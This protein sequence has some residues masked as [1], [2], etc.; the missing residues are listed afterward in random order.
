MLRAKQV[1][2]RE[3]SD[4]RNTSLKSHTTAMESGP[5]FCWHTCFPKIKFLHV[6]GHVLLYLEKTQ[7]Q[8]AISPNETTHSLDKN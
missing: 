6:V 7:E 2:T 8:T 3:E 1:S 5:Q 4:V